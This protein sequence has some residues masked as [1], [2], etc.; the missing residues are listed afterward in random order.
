MIVIIMIIII[1]NITTI[2]IIIIITF[3]MIIIIV[4]SQVNI[5]SA[6]FHNNQLTYCL[7]KSPLT[8]VVNF[9]LWI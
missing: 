7:R 3:V 4:E 8:S 1:V 6:E 2:I 5:L 9:D